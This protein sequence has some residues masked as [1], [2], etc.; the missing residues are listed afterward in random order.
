MVNFID[1]GIES[2]EVTFE[3]DAGRIYGNQTSLALIEIWQG[4]N[5]NP[6]KTVRLD[7]DTKRFMHVNLKQITKT[8]DSNGDE[9]VEVRKV[10]VGLC[11]EKVFTT[12]YHKKFYS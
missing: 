11:P 1:P 2:L 7:R 6:E 8:Y 12:P 10:P 4:G 3:N 5:D 9:R